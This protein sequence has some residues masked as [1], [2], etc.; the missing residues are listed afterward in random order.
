MAYWCVVD[1]R[2]VGV[3]KMIYHILLRVFSMFEKSD[4]DWVDVASYTESA[5]VGVSVCIFNKSDGFFWGY[6]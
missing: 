1:D 6:L 2:S 5:V 4:V 3:R